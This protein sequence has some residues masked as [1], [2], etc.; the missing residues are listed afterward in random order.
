MS[1]GRVAKWARAAS[2]YAK[3]SVSIP[4][5]DTYKSGGNTVPPEVLGSVSCSHRVWVEQTQRLPFSP[6]P[7]QPL[8]QLPPSEPPQPPSV[9]ETSRRRFLF[10]FSGLDSSFPIT[11]SSQIRQNYS[12]QADAAIHRLAHLHLRPPPLTAVSGLLFR[13]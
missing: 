13:P 11:M 3:V 5:Q 9:S 8:F 4:G 2:Q 1:P 7:F 12:T 10:L 6:M